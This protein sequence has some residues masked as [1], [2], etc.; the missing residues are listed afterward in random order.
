MAKCVVVIKS[1]VSSK[2]S[3]LSRV[4]SLHRACI[5][6]NPP[7]ITEPFRDHREEIQ[8]WY[9]ATNIMQNPSQI[10]FQKNLIDICTG[11]TT[12]GVCNVVFFFVVLLANS[13]YVLRCSFQ[14]FTSGKICPA[15]ISVFFFRTSC[16]EI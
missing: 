13:M 9:F 7:D 15:M 14:A 16:P 11:R 3:F 12:Q 2:I 10:L 5:A 6:C 8:F 4:T 1:I